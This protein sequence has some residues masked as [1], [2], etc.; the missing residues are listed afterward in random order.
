MNSHLLRQI[1]L[2]LALLGINA[3]AAAQVTFHGD[4][5][6]SGHYAGSGPATLNG[7]QW[8]FKAAG[9]IVASPTISDGV[10]YIGDYGGQFHAIDQASGKETWSFKS[11][12]PITSTAA[13]AAGSV[14]FVSSTGGLVS[15][16]ATSGK[17]KWVFATEYERRFEARNLHGYLSA[18]QTIPDAYDVYMSSPAVTDGRVYFG[19]GDGNVYAIDA[20]SGVMVWKFST[21]D[22]VH[23]SPTVSGG[24]VYVGS[25]DGN[26]YAIDAESGQQKWLFKGGQDPAIHNQV[27]FQASAAVVDG[28]VYVG[29]RDAHVYALDARTGRK[30]WDY[31]TNKSWVNTTPAVANGIVYAGT[32]DSSRFM[33]LD[34]ATGRL[35]FNFDAK[36]Y[37]FSSPAIAGDTAYFGTQAGTLYAVDAKAGKVRWSFQTE[38]ARL[39]RMKLL[40]PDGGLN[41]D[42]FVPVFGDFQDMYV[43]MYRFTT[44]G[45]ILSS[46]VVDHGAVYVASM[47]GNLYALK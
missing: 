32:S 42:A 15:L 18:G 25:W 43:D 22:V 38:A 3:G 5:T 37:V 7:V 2:C 29:C 19:S 47:D 8:T 6:R 12:M 14:Y 9:P 23:A 40:N 13:V 36:G 30:K 20:N 41:R 27:G 46:P 16:D 21:Q 28:A 10:I 45:A 17:L 11:R 44:V 39:D 1:C 31:P 26:F 4:V 34:A 35:R 33:A 24:T